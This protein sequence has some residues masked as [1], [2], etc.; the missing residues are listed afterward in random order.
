MKKTNL[1]TLSSCYNSLK[2]IRE[3]LVNVMSEE[4]ENFNLLPDKEKEGEAGDELGFE[5]DALDNID[6]LLGE[7]IT[8][9]EDNLG[10][11]LG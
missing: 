8:F 1:E 10:D 2:G 11:R 9:I 3:K 7:V 6:Y 5:I 4:E